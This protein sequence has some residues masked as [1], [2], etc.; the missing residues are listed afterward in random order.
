MVPP[1]GSTGNDFPDFDKMTLEEQMAWL[2]SL[3]RRQGASAEEFTTA[4]N[5]DIPELPPDT[6]VDEPGY[7]PF[8]PVT[9]GRKAQAAP[10]PTPEP[11]QPPQVEEPPMPVE[12]PLPE[13]NFDTSEPVLEE[14]ADP[15]QWLESLSAHSSE[16]SDDLFA[17]LGLQETSDFQETF[18]SESANAAAFDFDSMFEQPPQVE[19]VAPA[20]SD[21]P[22]GGMDP[23]L[24]LESLAKRQGAKTEELLTSADAEVQ[25]VSSDVV[26]DEP[27]YVPF[28]AVTG[29]RK[30]EVAPSPRQSEPEEL[31]MPEISEFPETAQ[32]SAPTGDDPLGG[33]DPM[34]WL[35]SL[36]KR[37]GAKT[38]ELTTSA[39][40]EIPE[41]PADTVVDEPGYVE[42]SAFS[43]YGRDDEPPARR[44]KEAAPPPPSM[45]EPEMA[46][47]A[48]E[49]ALEFES[50]DGSL[51]W[52]EDLAAESGTGP[53]DFLSFG[54]D[55]AA[56]EQAEAQAAAPDPNDPLAGMSDEEIA[57]A[58]AHQMLTGA[59]EFAWLQRQARKLAETRQNEPEEEFFEEE[60]EPAEP[61]EIPPWIQQIREEAEAAPRSE[62]LPAEP[63]ILPDWLSE[64]APAK[65]S[66]PEVA[67]DSDV[68][69]LWAETSE[70]IVSQSEPISEAELAAYLQG[71]LLTG[72][73]DQLAEALDAEFDRKLTG[74]QS[75]PEWYTSALTQSS[76]TIEETPES[77]PIS[78]EP[79]LAEA[80][81]V[82]DMPDW[83]KEQV[84]EEVPSAVDSDMP[85]W[86]TEK[87][88]PEVA[89]GASAMPD[90]LIEETPAA[91]ADSADW[92][93]QLSPE[94]TPE[95]VKPA[96]EPQF[97]PPQK[98]VTVEPEQPPVPPKLPAVP[99]NAL[100]AQYRQR[101]DVDPN[102]HPTRL[103]LAR[104]LRA[105][106]E[107]GWSLD[108]YE[109]L[110]DVS[111]L[112]Q[113]VSQ[114]LSGMVAESPDVPRLRRLLGD[115]YMR[116]GMLQ[117]ALDAYRSALDQL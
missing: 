89:A 3:A 85:K 60:I 5:L 61:G 57:Y 78:S 100:F 38:E 97:V 91:P 17:D 27:G 22:L 7:V 30:A 9:G 76:S 73:P 72:T 68:E 71:D 44:Q 34:R 6:V 114:D 102:D 53:A 86:L 16:Q 62:D 82:D 109:A 41:L 20:A 50:L 101:L 96:P 19:E 94:P 47:P 59:Q 80:A 23:M 39:D 46:Q 116:Q 48:E 58:Q 104:A 84:E 37:Q 11:V 15:M 43:D 36:A 111:Q 29:G 75:E 4:A 55:F 18:A 88:E 66:Q 45:P 105:Q 56:V 24:W 106:K 63:A 95:P 112:M 49:V 69:S 81:P 33:M 40:L 26:I 117:K 99:E 70:E 103:A 115:V 64:S 51:S 90:W 8:D 32:E 12:E 98:P 13:L 28:D 25:E 93:A 92:F 54:D 1:P 35:E 67:F 79:V 77:A 87:V 83:L 74:D 31:P 107:L 108:Q 110:I 113:D 10:A 42:Y 21:D 14:A 2:E 65:S 52:L